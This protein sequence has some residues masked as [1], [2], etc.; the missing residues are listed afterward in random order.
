MGRRNAKKKT[1]LFSGSQL[2][3]LQDGL[4]MNVPCGSL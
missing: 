3:P 2:Y 4:L 1:A